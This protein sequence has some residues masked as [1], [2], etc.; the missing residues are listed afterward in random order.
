MQERRKLGFRRARS[1]SSCWFFF[2]F[3]FSFFPPFFIFIFVFF[4]R[5]NFFDTSINRS[6]H[7]DRGVLLFAV[8]LVANKTVTPSPKKKQRLGHP[9]VFASLRNTLFNRRMHIRPR[10]R[11]EWD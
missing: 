8:A 5:P 2:F 3:F 4:F 9:C 11:V 1:L 7:I 10:A 6:V